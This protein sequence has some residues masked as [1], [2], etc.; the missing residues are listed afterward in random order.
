MKK[1][2]FLLI[3]CSFFGTIYSQTYDTTQYYGKMNYVF[4]NVNKTLVTTGLLKDYGIDF[5]NLD[6]YTGAILNDSNFTALD[7]WRML[8]A[9]LYSQQI[10]GNAGML[11]LDTLNR[12]LNQY[13][14][15]ANPVCFTGLY[16]NYQSLD[17]NTVNNNWMYVSND[18]LYDVSGR[19]Q[20]PYINNEMFAIA[21]I[22]QAGQIGANQFIFRSNLFFGNTGK[23]ISYIQIDP[24][25]TGVYQTVALDAAFTVNYD[26]AGFYN[27][28]IQVVYTD[29]T[30]KYAHTKLAVYGNDQ[31][32]AL[33]NRHAET[34]AGTGPPYR[35]EAFIY[36]RRGPYIPQA[37]TA[38]KPYLGVLAQGDYTVDLSVNNTTGQIRKPLLVIE[39]FDPDGGF[40]YRQLLSRINSD[41]NSDAL[42]PITLNSA[43]DD[44]NSYD[45]IFLHW[46]SGTDYIQRNAYLVEALIQ[47]VNGVKINFNGLPQQNAIIGMSM[48][49]LAVR[50]ALRDME[51]TGI[52][53]DTRLFI[54]HDAPHWGANIPVG[55]QAMV[56]QM[57]PFQIINFGGS[58]PFIRWVDL[59]PSAVDGLN[60]LNSPAAK[61]M[62]IQNYTLSGETLTADNSVHAA[63]MNELNAMGWPLNCRNV[64]L[65]NG[66]CSSAKPFPDNSNI[67]QISGAHSMSNF[68]SLWRSL[69]SSLLTTPMAL[70]LI[71]GYNGSPA[72][73]AWAAL[74]Q[75]PLAPFSTRSSIGID[76][77]VNSIPG[78]GTG[79]IYRGDVY[80]KK[81]ILFLIN[82]TNYF[83]KAH[84]NSTSDM[85]PLDNAPGG[86]Y[87]LDQF[88]FNKTQIQQQLPGFFTGYVQTMVTQPKFCFVPTVSALAFNNPQQYYLSNVCSIVNCQNPTQ[89]ADYYAPQQ[90][91]LHISYTQDN[92][93]WILQRQD[94]NFSCS[95]VCA[96]GLSISGP[97]VLCS[98]D[99]YT[100]NNLPPNTSIA[101]SATPSNIVS[102]SGNNPATVTRISSGPVNLTTTITNQ[103][104]NN[105]VTA[106]KNIHAGGYSSS[107]YPVSGPSSASC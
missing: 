45:L 94:P 52:N 104:G 13:G 93:N 81:Q 15:P 20:S 36:G 99:T 31:S 33:N 78:S 64:T 53:H 2:C 6:N 96:T 80:S 12:L 7:E 34:F 72:F 91:Q 40:T 25:G 47:W 65:S 69:V 41:I 5:L 11:Y 37:I 61:Q 56:Q 59:F 39:G 63:F 50:Y 3:A 98:S 54:S 10:N 100:L 57:A 71:N 46:K 43:L 92:T 68:G 16:Y 103:C 102:I 101:W 21:P 97:D 62:L 79:E 88:G 35:H 49:G 85:L 22:R 19:S 8:Y 44:I 30:V 1:I 74:W 29:N 77:K 106:S 28:N 82:V 48:G 14:S 9:S 70:G 67:V 60:L 55:A 86:T 90:N 107:D 89:V 105:N 26:T 76:F 4:A 84:V 83:I 17:P 95:K 75:F 18:Q 23:V 38:T 58:F 27:V 24:K 66:S 73:N 32:L 51:L 87:D 42:P